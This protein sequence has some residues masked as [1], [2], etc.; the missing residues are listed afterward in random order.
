MSRLST[1]SNVDL[2][3]VRVGAFKATV[4][5]ARHHQSQSQSQA[6]TINV[7]RALIGGE[8]SENRIKGTKEAHLAYC[9]IGGRGGRGEGVVLSVYN[10]A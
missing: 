9:S 6:I 3:N 4:S 7:R 1:V 2:T 5:T 10:S 8:R